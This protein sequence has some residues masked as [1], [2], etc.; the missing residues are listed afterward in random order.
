MRIDGNRVIFPNKWYVS[1]TPKL[2]SDGEYSFLNTIIKDVNK[3][4]TTPQK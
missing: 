4:K 1:T 2:G 3:R